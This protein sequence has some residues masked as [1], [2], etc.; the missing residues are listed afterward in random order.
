MA[1]ASMHV[2]AQVHCRI[3]PF[4]EQ[5]CA[6]LVTVDP[7][8]QSVLT[9][10]GDKDDPLSKGYIC[11][12]AY[13][14]KDLHHDPE[15]LTGPM[16]RRNGRLEPATWEEAL[17]Y[18]ARRLA[19]LQRDHGPN[20][21]AS[22]FGTGL[23][24]VPGLALY[25]PLLL[26]TLGSNQVYS[27]SS[28]DS[29]AHFM[30]TATMFG[31]L[32]SMPIPDIDNSDYFVLIGANPLQSNGSFLTA[33]GVSRRLRA[34]QAR[35]G[36]VVVIDPRRTETAEMADWHLSIQPGSDAVLLLAIAHVL[37]NEDLVNL[38]HIEVHAKNVE[39]LRVIALRFTPEMASAACG[40]SVKDIYQ[41]ARELAAAPRGRARPTA[42]T[43]R[44]TPQQTTATASPL[45]PIEP[46]PSSLQKVASR[47]NEQNMN[48]FFRNLYDGFPRIGM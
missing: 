20:A 16:M 7:A 17:E 35:G 41:L 4:C 31:G 22:Y 15:V 9:V 29:H 10:R 45:P 25:A 13:A 39:T 44:T 19:E 21:I 23:T 43:A 46:P 40:I 18:T 12:K 1:D 8:T 47:R 32:A 2:E 42:Q 14:L 34:I 27:A 26:T 5:N 28:V 24:H 36:K 33:P 11:P 3:C 30:A 38:G 6:T 37:F 48:T